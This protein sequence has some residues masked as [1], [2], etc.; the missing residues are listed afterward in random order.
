MAGNS[1][2]KFGVLI[3]AGAAAAGAALV[4]SLYWPPSRGTDGAIGQRQV[5][6]DGTVHAAD[7]AVTPGSAPVAVKAFLESKEFQNAANKQG[8]SLLVT[9]PAFT[10]LINNPAFTSLVTTNSFTNLVNN[11]A[12]TNLVTNPSFTNLVTNPSFTN[13]VTNPSFSNLVNNPG[14][15]NLVTS[16]AAM[17]H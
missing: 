6:R 3:G 7:V 12:F 15:A 2:K 17:G 4:A 14:F 1:R 13:L 5:Y 8:L 16:S 10:N 9:S 11:P